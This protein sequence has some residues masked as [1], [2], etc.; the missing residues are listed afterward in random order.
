MTSL[1][2]DGHRAIERPE[3]SG[4]DVVVDVA[5]IGAGI[6][7]LVT[8][9]LLARAGKRVLVVEALNPGAVTTG[10]TTGKVSL[11]QGSRLST[12]ESRQGA[13]SAQ[14]YVEGNREAQAWLVRYCADHGV[15]VQHEDAF[16]YAQTGNGR[17]PARAEYDA[18]RRAGLDVT[19]ERELEVPFPAQGG[20]RLPDQ[21]QL[22][23][24]PLL[25]ALVAELEERGGQLLTGRRVR[26]VLTSDTEQHLRLEQ[27]T[28]ADE[29]VV[30]ARQCVLA[31]GAPILDRGG[32]FARLKPQR[33]Y[34]TAFTVPTSTPRGM[35]LSADS[36]SRSVR[37]APTRDGERLI[38]GGNGHVVGRGSEAAAVADLVDWTTRHFPG[39]ELTHEWSAQDYEPIHELPFVGP[40]LPRSEALFVATGF[41]KWGMTNG[42][43]AALLLA[44]RLLGGQQ[45]PWAPAFESWTTK[46]RSGWLEALKA[47]SEVALHLASGWITPSVRSRGPVHEGA[48]VVAGLPWQMAARSVVDGIERC[49]SPVCTHLGGI[50]EWNDEA[51]SWD[52]PLHGSRFAADGSVLE[53]PATRNLSTSDRRP[54]SS[55]L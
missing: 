40:L 45:A 6:T 27:R 19:W 53:G 17:R 12:I 49:V 13:Q 47:N 33:S 25:D 8:A 4:R 2:L 54:T 43:A 55:A 15:P 21:V 31:T 36:P 39:A 46:E 7:G 29:P 14:Q 30:A 44:K 48:G 51:K 38:V 1:W 23:P 41:A 5:V 35:Y 32:Y 24:M 11:L 52:C 9:V 50:V 20:V 34:C 28:E 3:L 42:V 10:N 37:Y 22:D 26:T 16:T 18:C